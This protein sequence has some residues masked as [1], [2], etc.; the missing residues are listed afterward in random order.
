M[1][2]AAIGP[3]VIPAVN[4]EQ[5]LDKKNVNLITCGGQAT[6]PI[7]AAIKKAVNVQYAET[8]S[9]IASKSAGPGTR[10]NID[11]FTQTTRSGVVKIGGAPQGKSII[12]LNPA[13]PPIMMRNTIYAIVDEPKEEEITK[14][15][16][17]MVER[18]RS[19]VPGYRLKVPPLVEKK[20]VVSKISPLINGF[21]VITM[22][23]VEG[24]GD[25]LP[26]YAGNLDIQTCASIAIAE[27]FAQKILKEEF[28]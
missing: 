20:K 16:E 14:S 23:E 27:R 24:L 1:T 8:V 5:H 28:N 26:T 19:Y 18:I 17:L 4:L 2:P 11:E 22:I 9:T 12:I 13:E 15:V 25:Y 10:A 3:Y 21:K 7:V 6:V